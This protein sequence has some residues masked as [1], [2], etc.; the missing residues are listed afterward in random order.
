[1]G[2]RGEAKEG[3]SVG[4]EGWG[5]GGGGGG[6]VCPVDPVSSLNFDFNND[7]RSS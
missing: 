2:G 1:M 4:D 6:T 5:W 3:R 7:V